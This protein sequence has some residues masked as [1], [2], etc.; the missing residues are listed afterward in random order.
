[1]G[2]AERGGFHFEYFERRCEVYVDRTQLALNNKKGE[3]Q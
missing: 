2:K 1:M 3:E